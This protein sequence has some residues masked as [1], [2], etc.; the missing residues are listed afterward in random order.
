M[1]TYYKI[2]YTSTAQSDLFESYKILNGVH[3]NVYENFLQH[4]VADRRGNENKLYTKKYK[5]M[6]FNKHTDTYRLHSFWRSAERE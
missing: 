6:F 1:T 3:N 5:F 4:T 2:H